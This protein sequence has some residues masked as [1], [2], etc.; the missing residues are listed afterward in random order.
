MIETERLIIRPLNFEELKK[1][2][3]GPDELAAS[4]GLLPSDSLTEDETLDAIINTFLP[5]LADPANDPL[6]WTMWIVIE[7]SSRAITGGICFHGEPD[8]QGEVEIG[9]GT[10]EKFRNQGIMTEA[11]AG[12][13]GWLRG[14]EKIKSV[15][16]ETS[17][18]NPSSVKVLEKNNFKESS[19][20]E[21]SVFL[22]LSINT[23]Q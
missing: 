19:R 16:A 20:T 2:V 3:A 8:E 9:Y 15:K 4:L 14:I 22:N 13:I 23:H 10:D 17:F 21:S 1:L 5:N 18:D 12:I 7:K 6:F 11:I